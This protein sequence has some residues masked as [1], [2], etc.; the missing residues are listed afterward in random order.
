MNVLICAKNDAF[1]NG[2]INSHQTDKLRTCVNSVAQCLSKLSQETYDVVIYE[3]DEERLSQQNLLKILQNF[4]QQ[5]IIG[6]YDAASK[7]EVRH[8]LANGLSAVVAKNEIPTICNDVIDVVLFGGIYISRKMR[9][10]SD[11]V[12]VEENNENQIKA[13]NN[14]LNNQNSTKLFWQ[15]CSQVLTNRQLEI[16]TQLL[17][18]QSNREIAESLKISEGTVKVHLNSIYKKLNIS[19]R[20]QI[21]RLIVKQN[22]VH[23]NVD[24]QYVV[25]QN[26]VSKNMIAKNIFPK[27]IFP[28]TRAPQLAEAM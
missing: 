10:T 3:K 19:N 28:Q 16:V 6:V 7:S 9:Q 26:R 14:T 8:H 22:V 24:P 21:F 1:Y 5:K 12:V 25:H 11:S 4:P 27:T 2:V 17:E 13:A 15:K 23:Q 20:N 18:G